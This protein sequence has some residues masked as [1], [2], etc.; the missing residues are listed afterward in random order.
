MNDK[1]SI[2]DYLDEKRNIQKAILDFISKEDCKTEEYKLI[3]N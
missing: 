2:L 3:F 1:T